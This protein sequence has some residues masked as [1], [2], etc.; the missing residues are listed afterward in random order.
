M[1]STFN[2][3]KCLAESLGWKMRGSHVSYQLIFLNICFDHWIRFFKPLYVTRLTSYITLSEATDL[4]GYT[5]FLYLS[6]STTSSWTRHYT[7]TFVGYDD[8]RK[9]WRYC[10]LNIAWYWT[11][12]D[13]FDESSSWWALGK[14][15]LLDSKESENQLNEKVGDPRHGEDLWLERQMQVLKF[16]LKASVWEGTIPNNRQA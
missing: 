1:E 3:P 16:F 5:L 9:W 8:E 10:N 12:K 11:S 14:V 4:V 6:T 15:V 7:L 13:V 2:E